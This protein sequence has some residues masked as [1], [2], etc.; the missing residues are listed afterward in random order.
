MRTYHHII[1]QLTEARKIRLLTDLYSLA[2]PEWES[3]GV[4]QVNSASLRE[5]GGNVYPTPAALSRSW[6]AALI[7]EVSEQICWDKSATGI[8]HIILPPAGS[9]VTSDGE[10]LS[11]DPCVSGALAGAFLAGANNAG[12]TATLSGYGFTPADASHM[13]TPVSH[14]FSCDHLYTPV[15]TALRSGICAGV[16]AEGS[17]ELPKGLSSADYILFRRRAEDKETVT[18]LAAGELLI[19]GS[20]SALQSALHNHRRL[21]AAIE[22]GKATTGELETAIAAGEAM[23][24]DTLDDAVD[25]LLTFAAACRDGVAP[26]TPPASIQTDKVV[27]ETQETTDNGKEVVGESAKTAEVSADVVDA[28]AQDAEEPADPT[29]DPEAPD[30]PI[31]PSFDTAL[32]DKPAPAPEPPAPLPLRA[33]DGAT[34]LLENRDHTLPLTKPTQ[35]CIIGDAAREGG[36]VLPLANCL[37]AHGH[38]YVGY[39]RGYDPATPRDDLLTAE[40]EELAAASQ[41]VLLFLSAPHGW[42]KNK[43]PA[44][45]LALV[46][47]LGRLNKQV[48]LI[49]SSETAADMGFARHAVTPP[50]AILLTPLDLQGSPLHAVETIL[51]IRSPM[52]RLTETLTDSAD[53]ATDRRG[54]RVGP[55]VG[56]RYYDTVGYGATYP[57]G[58][59]LSYTK[60][61]YS[62]LKLQGHTLTFTVKNMGKRSG[63]AIPQIYVGIRKSD[64]LRPK[65][66]LVSFT[67]ISLAAGEQTTVTLPWHEPPVDG[68]TG[69]TEK[70][71]YRIYVGESVS[72]IRLTATLPAGQ[73]TVD[74]DGAEL[75]DYLP[76]SNVRKEHYT[77]EAEYTPMKPSLR[78]LLFGIAALAL[79][80]SVKIY[81]IVTSSGSVFLDIVAG[82]LAV[83]AVFFFVMEM[84]DRK[85][86]FAR[87]RAELEAANAALFADA[88]DIPVPSA[89]ALFDEGLYIPAEDA[90]GE[91]NGHAPADEFDHFLDADKELTFPVAVSALTTLAA[92]SGLGLDESTARGIFAAMASSRLLLV[93]DV[94]NQAFTSVVSLLS[95]YFDCPLSPDA[96]DESYVSES[97]LLF[98]T[99]EDGTKVKKGALA[100]I[101]AACRNPRSIQLVAL[102]DVTFEGM[103]A[104]F[105][106]YARY[107]RAPFSACTVTAHGEDGTDVAYRL[108]ENLWF[109]LNLRAGERLDHI[110]DYI[111]E[112]AAVQSWQVN[113][114]EPSAAEHK[115]FA[116]FR[117]GQMLYLCDRLKSTFSMEEDTWKRMDRLE[118]FG[119]R[120]GDFRMGNKLWIGLE[121]YVSVLLSADTA[122]A[123]A[124]DEALAVRVLPSL[125][126][127]LSGKLPREERGLSETMEAIFGEGN[128]DLCRKTVRESGA[129]LI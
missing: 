117:Y 105:V 30:A 103:S 68:A 40:A 34:V 41:T 102:T 52:G 65:K 79:A 97:D 86:Q 3:L 9:A 25:R 11:E 15:T 22:H 31:E 17:E 66:E 94:S 20:A 5:A 35:V 126:R 29:P 77:L 88:T 47:R 48:V 58:H 8:N 39:A 109:V 128:T 43:L 99:A 108:P 96:V 62:A 2:E 72:D 54:Y 53:P 21:K 50:A 123:A 71:T 69:L 37:T 57:F 45:E 28:P 12:M 92:E 7:R 10:R 14:R 125:I 60:F 81:D 116:P 129:D 36:D 73:D 119:N 80:V 104:Y 78:N 38:T 32:F 121:T 122:P 74:P 18:A 67:R 113:Y 89:D 59:G 13:D 84:M 124:L 49:L 27:E 91:G 95:E 87:E 42:D 70:G 63:V 76:I 51:G 112:V 44:A 118:A 61:R 107:A 23:S 16:I 127:V 55:F 82:L 6:D 98:G 19:Q 100:A 33:L 26:T 114:T 110:P 120:Y 4:P 1:S 93:K 106:P 24:E 101:D 75:H 56:Y 64:V 46:D 90:D 85:K 111:S 115:E 83:G